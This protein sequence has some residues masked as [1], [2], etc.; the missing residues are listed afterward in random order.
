M[1]ILARLLPSRP[2][3]DVTPWFDTE[4]DPFAGCP[5]IQAHPFD[6]PRDLPADVREACGLLAEAVEDARRHL[7][8][9][10]A[11]RAR[12]RIE[13]ALIHVDRVIG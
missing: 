13:R 3:R 5:T 7:D 2:P 8:N 11:E 10:R 9:G 12:E 4:R 6:V 1:S